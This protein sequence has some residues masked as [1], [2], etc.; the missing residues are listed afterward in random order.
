M[1]C[2]PVTPIAPS[3]VTVPAAPWNT[4]KRLLQLSFAVPF[5]LVQL[6]RVPVQLPEPPPTAPFAMVPAPSQN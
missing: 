4:A 3:T 2:M 5:A 6:V 1:N